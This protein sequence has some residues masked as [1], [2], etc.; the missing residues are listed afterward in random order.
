MKKIDSACSK[1]LFLF[2]IF[3]FSFFTSYSQW[4]DPEKVNPK[5]IDLNIQANEAAREGNYIDAI[6]KINQ[7]LIIDNRFVNAYLSRAAYYGEL[8][9]YDSS[10][11]D[12]EKSI[13]LDTVYSAN[14]FLAYSISLAGQGKF[15]KALVAV[16]NFLGNKGLNERSIKAASYRKSAYEFA[17]EYAKKHPDGNYVFAPKNLGDNVNSAYPEYYPSVTID[18]NKLVF[19]RRVQGDE[20]FY[21]CNKVNGQ[22]SKAQPLGG[23]VNTN[24]NEGAQN[25]SQDGEWIIFTGCNYPEGQ[26]SCDLYISHKTKT[27]WSEADNL[28]PILNT[29]FWESAPSLSPDKRDL[30]FSSSQSGGYGGKDIW[31]SHRNEKGKWSRAENI[32]PTVNTN[33]DES[34]A[35]MY[36]DN[37]TL[38]FNSNGHMGYGSTDLFYTKKQGDTAWAEPVNLGYPVNTIDDEGSM[39]VAADGKTAY[40]ASEGK[41]SRGALDLY[42]FELREDIR[43]PKTLWVKGQVFDAR[44]KQGLPSSVELTD[45]R[46]RQL[47]SKVQTDEEGNYLTTLPI[48]KDY[49]FNVNRK[50][51]LFFSENYDLST[52]KTDSVYTANIP[53]QPIEPGASI[54]LKNIFFDTKKTDLKPESITELNRVIQLMNDNPNLKI[55]I[56]GHTDNVGKPQDNILLSNNRALAVVKYLLASQQISKD[57]LQFKGLGAGK[58]IAD[59]TTDEGKASNRRT[60]MSVISN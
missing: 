27:G 19:T 24:L 28:G 13:A 59:N 38:F 14:F 10:C 5:A 2:F 33:G 20:D 8:K 54:V 1:T 4:Y 37:Q 18:G 25:I 44:T 49:A 47:L 56:S 35:F 40:Y 53:L 43:P 32:G 58:P 41:D 46:S 50:G 42:S 16:N 45:I 36:A 3:H 15:D 21:E 12:Y 29:D 48:G 7:A 11:A 6:A 9:Y 23:K 55:L 57:R 34:C 51:Y 31:V 17:I 22:W 39:I 52:D 30:Y 26:G 60:E